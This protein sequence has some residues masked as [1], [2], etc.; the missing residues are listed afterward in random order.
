MKTLLLLLLTSFLLCLQSYSQDWSSI[1]KKINFSD[2]LK[3]AKKFTNIQKALE[4]PE[5]VIYLDIYCG[6][7]VSNVELFLNEI[8]K[9]TNLRKLVLMNREGPVVTLPSTIWTL[10]KLEYLDL[11][12]FPD[13][14]IKGI[15]KLKE[16]K[17]LNL[18]G[19]G[20]DSIPAELRKL[21]KI[22]FLNLS[23]NDLNSLPADM[24][25][26]KSLIELEL[27]NNCF[28]EVPSQITQFEKLS[29]LTMNNPEQGAKLANGNAVCN[30]E[31]KVFPAIFADM[32][33]LKKVSLFFKMKIDPELKK[34]IKATY[35]KIKFT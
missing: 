31:I 5:E 13:S 30:N 4:A 11:F 33:N 32:K 16:L 23:C 26:L 8:P 24:G 22:E 10:E 21:E 34:K 12:N 18:D 28:T 6:K 1:G 15:S 7:D 29:F 17:Y 35:P 27:S 20:L 19:F 25:G 3:S 9:F 14:D 2:S